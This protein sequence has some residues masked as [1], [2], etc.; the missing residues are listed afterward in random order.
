MAPAGQLWTTVGGPRPVGGL[1]RGRHRRAARRP[2]RSRRCASRTT[3]ST[4]PGSRGPARTAS[5]GRSGTSTGHAVRRARRLDAG[6]PRRRCA[7]PDLAARGDGVVTLANTTS[8]PVMRAARRRPAA[9]PRRAGAAPRRAWSAAGD[10]ALLELVGTWHWG[11][12]TPPRGSTAST[13]SSGS[14][15]RPAALASRRVGDDEWV[16][17][18]GYHTGEPLRVVRRADGAV[19]HLD[20]ASFRFTRTPVRPGGRRARRASTTSAGTDPLPRGRAGA[21]WLWT[22]GDPVSG[23]AAYGGRTMTTHPR[24]RSPDARARGP[25]PHGAAPARRPRRRRLPRRPARGDLGPGRRP[26]PRARGPAHRVGQVGGVLRR[27][28][29]APGRGRRARRSSSARCWR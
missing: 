22:A 6:L 7:A 13:S 1:P 23:A 9:D 12:S 5:A 25:R 24:P 3:S 11:P 19:S 29:A 15:D 26:L 27:H 14:R 8:S 4:S 16:G 28:R 10:P 20:L 21:G 2:T 17:L 18:D